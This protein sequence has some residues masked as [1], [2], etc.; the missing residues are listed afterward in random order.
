VETSV[1]M[2]VTPL[3]F[4]GGVERTPVESALFL[5]SHA[6]PKCPGRPGAFWPLACTGE[7]AGPNQPAGRAVGLAA[8]KNDP[9][10]LSVPAGL[11]GKYNPHHADKGCKAQ[12][13]PT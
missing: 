6:A 2:D 10:R 12:P 11:I 7:D 3:R 9:V 1:F 4:N 13:G 8:R 5:P